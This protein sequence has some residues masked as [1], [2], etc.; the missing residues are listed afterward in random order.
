M[1]PRDEGGEGNHLEQRAD[2]LA[3]R[4]RLPAVPF[5]EL[6]VMDQE[7]SQLA[8]HALGFAAAGC[9]WF[10]HWVETSPSLIGICHRVADA[11]GF[12]FETTVSVTKTGLKD[13]YTNFDIE[14]FD[15]EMEN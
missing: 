4:V 10:A 6:C 2:H 9:V 15:F 12:D 13:A 14:A 8:D 3:G 11:H 1:K 5:S 7:V